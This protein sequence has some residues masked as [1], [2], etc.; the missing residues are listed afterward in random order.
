[1]ALDLPEHAVC[2]ERLD[3]R[4]DDHRRLSIRDPLAETTG[5]EVPGKSSEPFKGI[6]HGYKA[7]D[8]LDAG[9]IYCPHVPLTQT[10]VV[11]C[12]YEVVLEEGPDRGLNG[13]LVKPFRSLDDD[14]ER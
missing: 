5:G 11:L 3:V 4:D 8:F 10:P 2:S 7:P 6:L 13:R 12:P 9:Y 14:W 1:M